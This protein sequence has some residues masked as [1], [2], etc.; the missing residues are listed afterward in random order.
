MIETNL[1]GKEPIKTIKIR[2]LINTIVTFEY[3][4]DV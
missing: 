1:A 2:E 3:Q 4:T